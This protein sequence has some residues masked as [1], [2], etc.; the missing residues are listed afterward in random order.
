MQAQLGNNLS[1]NKRLAKEC[2]DMIFN[3]HKPAQAVAQYIGANYRQHNP[4][5]PDG[6]QGV[7]AYATGYLKAN[8]ELRLEFKRIIAEGDLVAV[9]SFLKPN[10]SDLGRA[11]VD[12]FRVEDGKLVEH[13]DVMQPV[14]LRAENKNTM[15]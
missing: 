11:V 15:F 1:L 9:H 7:I 12:I 5:A 8:P 4:H 3:Q 10:S 2:L 6:P 13:W 14:P